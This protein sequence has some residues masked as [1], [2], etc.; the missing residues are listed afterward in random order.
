M[1][2]NL[3]HGKKEHKEVWNEMNDVAVAGQKL[4]DEFL[5]AIDQ[6]TDAF[7]RVMDAFRL[8][9]KT[10]GEKKA[11]DQAIQ[12][13]T[14][15]ATLVPFGVLKNVAPV[16]KLAEAVAERG[17]PNSL[18][19]AGVAASTCRSAAEGACIECPD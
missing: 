2:A 19:D 3:T 9:K 18:S 13:A 15:E 6:D 10:D 5:V 11:R 12:D 4:K 17:N 14:K 1:V 8:P 16:L 7:N